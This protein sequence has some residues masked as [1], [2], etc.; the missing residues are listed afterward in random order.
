M[1]GGKGVGAIQYPV[2]RNNTPGASSHEELIP[3]L[4]K[5]PC[6][7]KISQGKVLEPL[8]RDRK[9]GKTIKGVLKMDSL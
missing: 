3:I 5:Y 9:E 4:P 8:G 2:V 7:F 1:S 6:H